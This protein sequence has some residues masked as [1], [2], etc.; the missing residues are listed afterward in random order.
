MLIY[1]MRKFEV[2]VLYITLKTADHACI[3]HDDIPVS[4]HIYTRVC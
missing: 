2:I 3:Y 1:S 4:T